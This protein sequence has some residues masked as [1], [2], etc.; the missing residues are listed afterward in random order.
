M[1]ASWVDWVTDACHHVANKFHFIVIDSMFHVAIQAHRDF[2][3]EGFKC[4]RRMFNAFFGNVKVH[5]AATE[6]NRRA[7]KISIIT[8]RFVIRAN[9]ST[10][11][12]DHAAVVLRVARGIFQC[13][14][15]AL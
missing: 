15:C 12:A 8:S 1:L 10:A 7:G 2:R 14:S 9:Q 13:L 5:I 6:K 4:F 11:Q 3:T